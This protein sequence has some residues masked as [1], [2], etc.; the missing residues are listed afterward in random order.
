MITVLIMLIWMYVAPDQPYWLVCIAG[1]IA[2][3]AVA[4]YKQSKEEK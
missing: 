4:G 3:V 1:G 2:M